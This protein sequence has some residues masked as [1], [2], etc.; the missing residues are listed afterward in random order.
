MKPEDWDAG[1]GRSIGMFLNGNGIRGMDTRGQRVIDDSFLL[2]FNAHDEP[3]DWVL[4][5]E[6]F[7]PAWRLVIDTSGVPDLPETIAGGGSVKVADKGMVV[8]QALAQAQE[9]LATTHAAAD[10]PTIAPVPVPMRAESGASLTD[11][12]LPPAEHREADEAQ[13]IEVPAPDP[14]GPEEPS[15]SGQQ[16]GDPEPAPEPDSKSTPEPEPVKPAARP[17]RP[18]K[19]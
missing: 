14:G 19:K 5:P 15:M 2:L 9:P 17:R 18:K 10:V 4:P 13:V 16:F 3:M 1:F 11:Q 6:E 7:A 8:L 12:S